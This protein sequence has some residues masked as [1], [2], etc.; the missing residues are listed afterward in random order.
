M[1]LSGSASFSGARG[2]EGTDRKS[3]ISLCLNLRLSNPTPRRKPLF[4]TGLVSSGGLLDVSQKVRK[5]SLFALRQDSLWIRPGIALPWQCVPPGGNRSRC[6]S[7]GGE[8]SSKISR[9]ADGDSRFRESQEDL[10]GGWI[11]LGWAK[12]ARLTERKPLVS[13]SQKPP[14]SNFRTNRFLT[15]IS[16]GFGKGV[17]LNLC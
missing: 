16:T 3:R 14:S 15:R 4:G 13:F 12:S 9:K 10:W 1:D 6:F 7:H 17:V 5:R 11:I 8:Q 2:P